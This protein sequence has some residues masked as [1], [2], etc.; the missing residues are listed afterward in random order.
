MMLSAG[1]LPVLEPT[2]RTEAFHQ[3]LRDLAAKDPA[4]GVALERF[5]GG[6]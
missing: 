2:D 1:W 3:A 4:C 6:A 5:E